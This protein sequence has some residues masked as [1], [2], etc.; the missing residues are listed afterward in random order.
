MRV[1]AVWWEDASSHDAWA[2]EVEVSDFCGE[3]CTTLTVGIEV[4][5]DEKAVVVMTATNVID[6]S[7]GIW[8]IPRGMV[9]KV[10]VLGKV[11]L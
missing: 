1:L 7:A 6:Q 9:R 2:S 8:R 3:P 4:S 5:N 10:R 11:E